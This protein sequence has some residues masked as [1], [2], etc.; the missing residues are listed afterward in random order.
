VFYAHTKKSLYRLFPSENSEAL[1]NTTMPS[2]VDFSK[3]GKMFLKSLLY[4]ANR[5]FR[6]KDGKPI[7]ILAY[8]GTLGTPKVETYLI[9]SE[10]GSFEVAGVHLMADNPDLYLNG[11]IIAPIKSSNLKDADKKRKLI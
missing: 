2:S 6:S 8:V 5:V 9:A 3:I 4:S 10:T 1:P 11:N 7:R